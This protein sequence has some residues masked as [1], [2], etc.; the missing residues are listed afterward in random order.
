MAQLVASALWQIGAAWATSAAI[1]V[2]S[3]AVIINAALL[4][5]SS[6]AV[7]SYQARSAARSARNAFN[8]SLRDRIINVATVDGARSRVYGRVRVADG[9]L[10]KGTTGDKKQYLTM[11][12]ALA[13]HEIDAVEAIYFNDTQVS[14]DGSGNVLTAPWSGSVV[15]TDSITIPP[16][17]PSITLSGSLASGSISVV[18][19]GSNA[20]RGADRVIS[21]SITGNVVTPDAGYIGQFRSVLFQT[22][23]PN[24]K[25]R[26][27]AFLGSSFQ[28]LSSELIADFPELIT[29]AHRFGNIAAVFVLGVK[30]KRVKRVRAVKRVAGVVAI[31]AVVL[32]HHHSG[33]SACAVRA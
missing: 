32:K 25:V 16:G 27:R 17:Q 15:A 1:W 4:L 23:A 8:S 9:V 29:S 18:V 11:V 13:G 12:L 28:N 31:C 21:Y 19:P 6:R 10:F 33:K 7:S 26:V 30:V 20:G 3:N 24:S 5:A 2:A 14:L 22:S